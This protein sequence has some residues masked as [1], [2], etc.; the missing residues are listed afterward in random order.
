MTE[1]VVSVVIPAHAHAGM[2][3]RCTDAVF[4]TAPPSIPIE[5]VVVDDASSPPLSETTGWD[6]RVRIVRSDQNLRFAGACNLG[7]STCSAPNLLFLNNDV[8]P[9]PGWLEPMLACVDDG[10]DLV[11]IRLE[12]GDGTVQHAGI[13]F[14]QMDG[15][16][17]HVYRGFPGDHPAVVA[18]RDAQA[19]TAACLMITRSAFEAVG[20]FDAGFINGFED[21]DLCLRAIASGSRVVYCGRAVARHLESVSVRL[22][23]EQAEEV[24]ANAARFRDR[25]PSVR[26]DEVERYITDGLLRIAADD[27]YPL[28]ITIDPLLGVSESGGT[29]A[30]G[31][32]LNVRSRQVFDLEK[33]VGRLAA[34]LLDHGIEP[35]L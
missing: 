15:M 28:T 10:A 20:G 26:P 9:E 18:T 4:E 30:I 29:D 12:Y 34:Q 6:P 2:T 35:L 7:A 23:P 31:R 11:G 14:S 8:M 17:R 22:S 3:R 16:P 24:A 25:W 13:C 5:V 1:P 33:D 19:V 27:I 32:L 21:V